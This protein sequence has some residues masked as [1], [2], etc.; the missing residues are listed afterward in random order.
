MK[1]SYILALIPLIMGIGCFIIFRLIGS[2]VAPDGTL[3]EPFALVPIGWLLIFTGIIIAI[4]L[5]VY[6]FIKK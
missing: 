3:I 1:K 4:I 2:S 5:S 6:Y